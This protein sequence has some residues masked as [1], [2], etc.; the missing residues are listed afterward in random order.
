M[1][2]R[3]AAGMINTQ[4]KLTMSDLQQELSTNGSVEIAGYTL[5][6]SLHDAICQINY[7]ATDQQPTDLSVA[8]VEIGLPPSQKL[9]PISQKTVTQWQQHN[10]VSSHFV[11]GDSFWQTQEITTASE[12]SNYSVDY[13]VGGLDD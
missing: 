7:L 10:D 9:K 5:N 13:L 2:V 1:R 3:L 11:V 6:Q 12:L 8:W 4:K